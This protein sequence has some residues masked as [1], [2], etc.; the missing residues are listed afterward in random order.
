MAAEIDVVTKIPRTACNFE[1]YITISRQIDDHLPKPDI[2]F[3]S[4]P[5]HLILHLIIVAI[6][7][8][9]ISG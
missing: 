2:P 4:H 5:A 3:S 8:L 1:T 7:R 6:L 9:Q